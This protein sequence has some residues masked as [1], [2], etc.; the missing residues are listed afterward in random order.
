MEKTIRAGILGAAKIASKMAKTML[1]VDG[2]A[3]C[4]VASRQLEKAQAF[5]DALELP[6][7]APVPKAYGSYEEM[8]KDPT[9][10]LIYVC[11]PQSFHYPH[12]MLCLENGKSVLCEKAFMLNAKQAK[13]ATTLAK[14]KGLF[15]GEAIWTR[16]FPLIEDIRKALND[17]V[18][19]APHMMTASFCVNNQH[20]QRMYDPALGGG[21]LLDLG[22]YVLTCID[23]LFGLDYD[24]FQ[25][26]AELTELGVDA[27]SVTTFHYPDGRT[28]TAIFSMNTIGDNS[29][30]VGGDQGYLSIPSVTSWTS[31]K[32]YD[33]RKNLLAELQGPEPFTGFE[34]ELEAAISAIRAG[35]SECPQMP[36][37]RIV[38]MLETMD[39]LR[40][41]WGMVLPG[42]SQL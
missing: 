19:G 20:N 21:A 28:A 3:L 38:R 10:D 37:E 14:E 33:Q 16:F 36:H 6:A 5:I 1:A 11:T 41:E 2:I 13:K 26:T 35:K 22:V 29:V 15:L 39:A 12:T 32:A 17:G 23:L 31:A 42:D 18:I 9:L 40:Q 7:D 4:A 30:I 8:V 27:K 25:T 24:S 34:Y